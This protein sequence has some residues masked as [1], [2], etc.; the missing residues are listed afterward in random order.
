M[1]RSRDFEL[2][3]GRFY[4]DYAIILDF[5]PY[6][7]PGQPSRYRE[8]LAQALGRDYFTLFEL[9]TRPG[10]ILSIG[11]IVYIGRGERDKIRKVNRR[12]LYDEL[13]SAARAE[14]VNVIEK[15]V[16]EREKQFLD[17][18]N[19]SEPIS[20]RMHALEAIPGIGKKL[21]TKILDER[22]KKPFTSYNDLRE[23]VG[24][25]DPVKIISEK[26]LRELMGEDKYIFFAKGHEIT[27]IERR[28]FSPRSRRSF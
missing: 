10:F 8:P 22:A 5:L 12:L 6:G 28:G 21:L 27:L 17:F 25:P 18:F 24:I 9:I 23:R 1:F 3:K 14:L 11:E 2:F 19:K 15:I 20:P 4:E 16:K 13:T 7:Y 26:I